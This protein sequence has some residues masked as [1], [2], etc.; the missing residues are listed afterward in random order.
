MMPSINEVLREFKKPTFSMGE[1]EHLKSILKMLP[2]GQDM[3]CLCVQETFAHD[4]TILCLLES[5]ST[6][7]RV[8]QL[9]EHLVDFGPSSTKV[10]PIERRH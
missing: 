3:K 9:R 8:I 1:E 4:R 6:S 10:K 2:F 5:L 7:S